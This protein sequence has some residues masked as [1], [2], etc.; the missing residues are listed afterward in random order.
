MF[1][2]PESWSDLTLTA[3]LAMCQHLVTTGHH[4]AM[5]MH[6]RHN[7]LL[8]CQDIGNAVIGFQHITFNMLHHKFTYNQPRSIAHTHMDIATPPTQDM[9]VAMVMDTVTIVAVSNKMWA[10]WSAVAFS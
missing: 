5:V 4:L 3:V 8:G 9:A 10:E 2:K 6:R 1:A 7:K